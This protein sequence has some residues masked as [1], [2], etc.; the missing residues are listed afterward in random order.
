MFSQACRT[1]LLALVC[2]NTILFAQTQP[3]VEADLELPLAA[4]QT[5]SAIGLRPV[6]DRLRELSAHPDSADR[7]ETLYLQQQALLRITTASLQVDASAE[8]VDSEIAEIRELENYLGSR[9][10][11]RVFKANLTALLVGGLA[12]T[13][14]SALGFSSHD[15]AA[16]ALGVVGGVGTTV[17]SLAALRLTQGESREL[18]AQ[19]N[20]LSK[21]FA[22][23]SD[24]NN[25]YPP[26]VVSFM[27][28]VAPNDEDGLSRQ[29]RLIHNWV[30]LGRIPDPNLPEGK[31]RVNHVA[32]LPGQHVQQSISDLEDRQA[33]LYDLRVR[34]N[35]IKL[36]LA[37]LLNSLPDIQPPTSS[38]FALTPSHST[39]TH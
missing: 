16:A 39:D 28:A 26:I 11:S 6:Y 2:A 18:M 14:S 19:S 13:V 8:Q 12:G 21:V 35:Y 38:E 25:V 17:L 24:A 30:E 3:K 37:I 7:W 22:H 36:D 20:M 34:L 10:D 33:M 23:P 32:S 31:A 1:V 15:H 5:A 4:E 29:D 27:N 9:R